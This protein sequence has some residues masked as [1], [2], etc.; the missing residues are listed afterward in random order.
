MKSVLFL[1]AKEIGAQCLRFL[2]EH[3]QHDY[4]VVGIVKSSSSFL[5][6]KND[7]DFVTDDILVFSSIDEVDSVDYIVSVQYDKILSGNQIAKARLLAIN[8]HMAPVPEY[9]GSNQFSFA[10]AEGAKQFGTTIHRLDESVDGGDIIFEDRFD[11]SSEIFVQELYAQTVARSASLFEYAWP[12]IVAGDYTFTPQHS[13]QGERKFGFHRRKEINDLKE[14]DDSWPIEKKK[15]HFRACYFP[16][17]D[18]PY[19]K[20]S[21]KELDLDWYNSL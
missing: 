2:L 20:G 17:H 7:F 5:S 11:I 3:Q 13:F 8:L 12:K 16:P 19:I 15:R 6:S 4:K 10:I 1:G 18:P 9:R 21:G 14:I